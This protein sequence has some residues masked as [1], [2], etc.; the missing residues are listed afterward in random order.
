MHGAHELAHLHED[1]V[2]HEHAVPQ[3]AQ[4]AQRALHVHLLHP[5]STAASGGMSSGGLPELLRFLG[6]VQVTGGWGKSISRGWGWPALLSSPSSSQ[7]SPP[8]PAPAPPCLPF[9]TRGHAEAVS[10]EKARLRGGDREKG[11]DKKEWVAAREPTLPASC[12][13]PLS[14]L[15]RLLCTCACI[16]APSP[17]SARPAAPPP[18]PAPSYRPHL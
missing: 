3:A 2:G 11:R 15:P 12:R 6:A 1:G 9:R 16:Y 18:P 8:R 5:Q 4:Q 17:H 14:P 7:A 10:E 13:G